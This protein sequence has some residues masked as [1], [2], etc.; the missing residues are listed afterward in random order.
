LGHIPDLNEYQQN[1]AI[2]KDKGLEIYRYMNFDQIQDYVNVAA[3][4]EA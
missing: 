4:V 1:I 3:S 2:I